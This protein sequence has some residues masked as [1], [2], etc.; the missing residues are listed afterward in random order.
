MY[1]MICVAAMDV[2]GIDLHKRYM[3]AAVLDGDGNLTQETRINND[4]NHHSLRMFLSGLK[5]DTRIVLESSSVW[6]GVYRFIEGCGFD[7]VLSNPLKTKAI[8]YGKIKTDRLDARVLADLLRADYIPP[9]HVPT[10]EGM[11]QRGL[12]RHREYLVGMRTSLKHKIHAILLMNNIRTA[13]S[14][15]TARHVY[16]LRQIKDYRIDAYLDAMDTISAQI[17]TADKMI[18]DT[19]GGRTASDAHLLATIPG[20]GYYSALV[21]A[22]EIGD[23]SRFPHSDQLVSYAGMVPS[24]Y[25]SGGKVRHGGITK[26]GSSFLRSVLSEC[27]LAHKRVRKESN[28]SRFHARIA[29]KKGNPKATVAAAAKLLRVCYWLLKERREYEESME[30]HDPRTPVRHTVKN[31]RDQH[32]GEKAP[33]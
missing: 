2:V 17:R 15:F 18:T 31:G 7:I 9:C 21:I 13:H 10:E 1:E 33:A 20:V 4:S 6:Y 22:S 23:I 25:S 12:A 24:T 11:E 26:H 32:V 8:A 27:V 5:P 19:V 29:R 14:G 16:E 3:Q 30:G 28:I